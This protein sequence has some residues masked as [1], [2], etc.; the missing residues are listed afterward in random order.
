MTEKRLKAIISPVD[1]THA[2]L[3][4]AYA[5]DVKVEDIHGKSRKGYVSIARHLYRYMWFCFCPKPRVL[6]DLGLGDRSSILWSMRKINDL[7]K[8]D[9]NIRK[10]VLEIEMVYSI[11]II[12]SYK[13]NKYER[14]DF[15]RER[16]SY[17]PK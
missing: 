3:F 2:D 13:P 7:C 8:V 5:F 1:R 17:I 6:M 4:C 11:K 9:K 15:T 10:K 14:F 12:G 16:L